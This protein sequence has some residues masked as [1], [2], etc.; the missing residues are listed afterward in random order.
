MLTVADIQRWDADAVREVFHAATARADVTRTVSRELSSLE[1]FQTWGGEA[2]DAAR[3][4][5]AVLRQDL[6]AHGVEAVTV[7]RAAA[8]AAT[9]IEEIQRE[10]TALEAQARIRRLAID[11]YADLVVPAAGHGIAVPLSTVRLQLQVLLNGLL[12]R[13][14]S[15]NTE[16]AAAIDMADGDRPIAPGP[17]DQRPDIQS[18][19]AAPP[20]SDPQQFHALW[21][22]LTAEEKDWLY[23]Q[24]H[25]IGNHAGMEFVDKDHYNRRH[26]DELID[27]ARTER[28]R[29]GAEHPDWVD[30]PP[31]RRRDGR[32][33]MDW[34]LWNAKWRQAEHDLA[35]YQAVHDGL[36]SDGGVPHLLGWIDDQG[37]AAMSIGDPDHAKRNALFVPG[38]AQDLSRWRFSE[39]KAKAMFKAAHDADRRLTPADVAVTTWMGYDRPMNLLEA[40][41][42]DR[43][44]SGA[45]P[46]GRFEE[47]MR[48]SH[49]GPRAVDTVIGHSYG[50][51]V[52][53]ASAAE[54]HH[55]SADRVVAVGAPGMLVDRA[56]DLDLDPGG[57]VY[58][59]RAQNDII[60]WAAGGLGLGIYPPDNP[61]FGATVLAADPGPTVA[62]IFPSVD[63]HSSYWNPGNIALANLGAV[64][65]GVEPPRIEHR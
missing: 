17:H 43:A 24:Y 13:A 37:H 47:G 14:N 53:G 27:A 49:T 29:L 59:M 16:L 60:R 51:V 45:D 61:V 55:L 3:H 57:K 18:A 62:G 64:I 54:G 12:E 23:E 4:A 65:A 38:T 2:A 32:L 10:L 31:P 36:D 22:A 52:L 7:A 56:R 5:N 26:L 6:D 41:V 1:V 35:G 34:L 15:V 8:R 58:A 46:L 48:A 28:D 42:P 25:D 39:D 33:P 63:A 21:Q 11:P 9:G 40:A 44:R 50:A 19:L 30:T 20:P